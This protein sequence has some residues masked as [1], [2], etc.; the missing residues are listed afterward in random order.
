L[1]FLVLD[2]M[3][4]VY[5]VGDDVKDL[6]CPFVEDKG[7]TKDIM[8]IERLY[9]SASLGN[10]SAF[11]F[12]K[13]VGL[14]PVLEDEYLLRHKLTDGLIN[15]LEAVSSRGYDIWCLSNDLSEWSKKLRIRF[16]LDRYIRSFVISGDV[17][18]RKP[19][20]AIFDYLVKQIKAMPH[21]IVFVDD[22][23]KNLDPAA[24]L[25]FHTILFAPA[26]YNLPDERH[27]IAVNFD[28]LLSLLT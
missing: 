15:F 5:S 14:D 17:G 8:K 22:R 25:G 19:D 24:E 7:G 1:K 20:R 10:M 2:A 3:G 18:I 23:Q 13:A 4:V 6:L 12:W 21:D 27:Q 16:G 28:D 11:E 26:G 9:H